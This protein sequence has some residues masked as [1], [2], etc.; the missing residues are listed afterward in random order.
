MTE[1]FKDV[2]INSLFKTGML[3]IASAFRKLV[4]IIVLSD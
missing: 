2:K 3:V 1:K 4:F